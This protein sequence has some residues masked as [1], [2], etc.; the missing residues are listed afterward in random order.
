MAKDKNYQVDINW[1]QVPDSDDRLRRAIDIILNAG[2]KNLNCIE[3]D[4]DD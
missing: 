2:N 4:N 1:I 3:E